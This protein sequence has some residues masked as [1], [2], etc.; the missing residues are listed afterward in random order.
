MAPV[1]AEETRCP[2]AIE[3]RT[4]RLYANS[5]LNFVGQ[6][7][8]QCAVHL[9]KEKLCHVRAPNQRKKT[10]RSSKFHASYCTRNAYQ[11][12]SNFIR[13]IEY[14]TELKGNHRMLGR[15]QLTFNQF[16]FRVYVDERQ[17]W[18]QPLLNLLTPTPITPL[19]L[20]RGR[21]SGR[22][23]GTGRTVFQVTT[24]GRKLKKS[25]P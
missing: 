25:N 14:A 22:D 18:Q 23:S 9:L 7:P 8:P 6:P 1:P 21:H 11:V 16:A 12:L 5:S 19:L 24:T 17:S 15:F 3:S 20:L 4:R 10:E 13:L 2:S